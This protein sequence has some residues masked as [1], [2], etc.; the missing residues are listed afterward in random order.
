MMPVLYATGNYITESTPITISAGGEDP[1]YL[2][3]NL[4][5]QRPGLPFRATSN[6]TVTICIDAT[7]AI[8]PTIFGVI[9]HNFATVTGVYTLDANNTSCV[10]AAVETWTMT[11]CTNHNNSVRKITPAIPYRYWRLTFTGTIV[12]GGVAV[13]EI[14]ELILTTWANFT[15][16]YVVSEGEGVV[17]P[18]SSQKTHYGQPWEHKYS[19]HMVFTLQPIQEKATAGTIDEMRLFLQSLEG[20][21]GRFIF[22]PDD[23]YL[24]TYCQGYYGHFVGQ[25]F[26]ANR[27]KTGSDDLLQWNL[28]F[29]ELPKGIV[30]I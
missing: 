12:A 11:L 22:S 4:Y 6:V 23:T 7:V 21:A 19:E 30:M 3:A 15:N 18:A 27:I 26:L 1:L 24:N 13:I 29:E 2:K 14:G 5:N 17:V 10:A 20:A 28:R 16:F 25:E 8:S 9:N